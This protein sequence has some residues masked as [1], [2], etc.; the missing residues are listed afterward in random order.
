MRNGAAKTENYFLISL[1]YFSNQPNYRAGGSGTGQ[2][3]AK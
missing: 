2:G 1:N 3:K